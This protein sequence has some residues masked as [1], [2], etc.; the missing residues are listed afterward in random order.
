V[1]KIWQL[2]GGSALSHGTTGTMVNPAL[3]P[4]N[5]LSVSPTFKLCY[6]IAYI[7]LMWIYL[8]MCRTVGLLAVIAVHVQ[9]FLKGALRT[10]NCIII[11]CTLLVDWCVI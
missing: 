6:Q 7:Q 8:E 3:H 5:N 11:C 4:N 10:A 2:I 1:E 9:I